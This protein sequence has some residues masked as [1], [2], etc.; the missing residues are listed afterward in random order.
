MVVIPNTLELETLWVSPPLEARGPR[1]PPP[2]ARDRVSARCP[3][4]ADG[5][6]DQEALF[7][8]SVRGLRSKRQSGKTS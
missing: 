2:D 3:F 7:P 8:R 6:L 1:P 4:S 5:T